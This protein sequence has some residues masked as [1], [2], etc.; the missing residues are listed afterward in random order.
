MGF[1]KEIVTSISHDL[2]DDPGIGIRKSVS[3]FVIR[4][5]KGASTLLA[6]LYICDCVSGDETAFA[7]QKSPHSFTSSY[8]H[9]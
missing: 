9:H 7:N 4:S 5:R 1:G 2:S 6:P 3:R 8:S